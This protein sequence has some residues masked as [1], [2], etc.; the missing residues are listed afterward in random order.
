MKKILLLV[1]ATFVLNNA[2]SQELKW[3]I[4]VGVNL[5]GMSD[6]VEKYPNDDDGYHITQKDGS[7]ALLG[8]HVGVYANIKMGKIVHFQPELLFSMQGAKHK[9]DSGDGGP[10]WE[11]HVYKFGYIQLP[12]LL[13]IKPFENFGILVGPQLGLNV[14]RKVTATLKDHYS[15]TMSG[16]DFDNRYY[17]LKKFD[18][19]MVFGFQYT[20]QRIIIGARYNLGLV[21]SNDFPTAYG[22]HW[23]GWRSNA[24][25]AS[26]GY[27]F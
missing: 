5:S 26:L 23:K 2:F 20:I 8:Y 4:K 3:G 24:L 27:S 10:V 11:Q 25:Q 17:G 21:D 15:E 6:V 22:S 18:P 13:E 1:V 14:S 7:G 12:L 9:H 16:S 19:A